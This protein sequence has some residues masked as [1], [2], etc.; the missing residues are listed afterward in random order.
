MSKKSSDDFF[1]KKHARLT[2]F[3]FVA[4][5][6]AW[7]VFIVHI[8]LVWGKYVEVQNTYNYQTIISG[9]SPHFSEMLRETPLYALSLYLD[10]LG[11]FLRGIVFGLVLKGIS[12][13][14]YTILEFDLNKKGSN[15]DESSPVFYKPQDILW[16][17]NWINRASIA[18]IG[19]T[20]VMSLFNFPQAKEMASAFM[21]QSGSDVSASIGAGVIIVLNIIFTSAIYYFL[22]KSLSSALKILMEVEFN[23]RRSKR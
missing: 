21:F 23:S 8:F 1:T 15:D 2:N 9:G 18:V 13:G 20:A 6:F 12:L 5:I 14:L 7:I 11:I 19:L 17:E 10:L 4:N 22:L 16:L 3:A